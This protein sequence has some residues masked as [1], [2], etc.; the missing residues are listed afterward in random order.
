MV[1]KS[2]PITA[3]TR[4][5]NV[6]WTI[7]AAQDLQSFHDIDLQKILEDEKEKIRQ[8]ENMKRNMEQW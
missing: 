2:V 6:K 7:E 4:K 1:I 5:L 3:K 8:E